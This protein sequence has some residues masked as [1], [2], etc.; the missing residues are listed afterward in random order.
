M[1]DQESQAFAKTR[2]TTAM[3][4]ITAVGVEIAAL[5]GQGASCVFLVGYRDRSVGRLLL[6]GNLG[7]DRHG[8]GGGDDGFDQRMM[9]A[10]VHVVEQNLLLCNV[11]QNVIILSSPIHSNRE[12]F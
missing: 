2:C 4:A 3:A 8:G 5:K 6:G 7:R 1:I 12:W 11:R 9:A 10:A